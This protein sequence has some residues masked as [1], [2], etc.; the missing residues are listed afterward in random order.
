M[1]FMLVTSDVDHLERSLLN[2]EAPRNMSDISVTF[3]VFHA[4]MS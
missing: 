2:K 1:L 4:P 3:E